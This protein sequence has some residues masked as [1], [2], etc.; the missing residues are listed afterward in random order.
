MQL[1]KDLADYIPDDHSRQVNLEQMFAEAVRKRGDD[2]R[3]LDLGCGDGRAVDLFRRLDAPIR[4]F[5][6]DIEDS[7]EV[8]SRRRSDMEFMVFDGVT[9]P[10]EDDYFDIIYS[11]QVF[12][13]VRYPDR[14]CAEICRTLKPGGE[15]IAS[16][17]FLEP[18]HSLSIFHF[19]PNG[20]CKVMAEAGL[21]PEW[22][23]PGIDG[24]TL[25]LHMVTGRPRFFKRWFERE[26]PLNRILQLRGR[27]LRRSA[28]T[29][30]AMKLVV[31]GHIVFAGRKPMRHD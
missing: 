10:F 5:G 2:I 18:Y 11:K 1:A 19:S 31:A 17:S 20:A 14:L 26:S 30:N 28:R 25:I 9:I 21:E 16:A 22:V 7:P 29:I 8:R 4:Y 3:V 27:L 24:A 12:E 15:F 6:I 23:R 13:H